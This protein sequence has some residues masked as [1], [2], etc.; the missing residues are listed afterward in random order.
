MN[1][2]NI[3]FLVFDQLQPLDLFGPLDALSEVNSF[4]DRK[5]YNLLLISES[6][7]QVTTETGIPIGCHFSI[8][9]APAL[10][11]LIIPGGAGARPEKLAGR[12]FEWINAIAPQTRRIC[13]VCTGAYILGHTGLLNGKK[14]TS[15][16]KFIG[17]LSACFPEINFQ[18]DDLYVNQDKFITAA[19]VTA[20]IDMTLAL[21]E[22]DLG[23]QV[24]SDV[25]KS[26]VVY[27]RRPGGQAQYS[28][29]LRHQEMEAGRFKELLPWIA[30]NLTG[31][32]S[33][34]AL[35]DRMYLGVRH[36]SRKFKDTF[37]GTPAK[38]IEEIKIEVAKSQLSS[39]KQT[40]EQIA[41]QTGYQSSDSFRRSFKR[42][43][44]I[45]PSEYQERFGLV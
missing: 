11:T 10:D 1:T 44:G 38:V 31:D 23:K 12:V 41:A 39:S 40:I 20:G 18:Y 45:T 34:E 33:T 32:L 14:A 7:H 16:W 24:A 5:K 13:S 25:A 42:A 28:T 21:I 19:G 37:G 3:G 26:L 30:D 43:T 6:G 2:R 27:L 9:A 4:F 17:D 15:H 22:D 35:A 36:F 8:D 29:L